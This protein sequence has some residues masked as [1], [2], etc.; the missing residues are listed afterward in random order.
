MGWAYYFLSFNSAPGL[1]GFTGAPN[2]LSA[3]L[4]MQASGDRLALTF[5]PQLF[6]GSFY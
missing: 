4:A 5:Q 1:I 6:T 3:K 2:D